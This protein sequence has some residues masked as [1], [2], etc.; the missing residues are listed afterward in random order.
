MSARRRHRGWAGF[1]LLEMLLAVVVLSMVGV[2]V[3]TML[4]QA[5]E[6]S[7]DNDRRDATLDVT[8]VVRLMNEQWDDRRSTIA[9]GA[10]GEAYSAEPGEISFVTARSILNQEWP[11]V[12][13]RY[14]VMLDPASVIEDER[15]Y[16]LIYEE[17]PL[18]RRDARLVA[19]A[20]ED[21]E[22]ARARMWEGASRH[23]LLKR[24]TNLRMERFR[25]LEQSAEERLAEEEGDRKG[26]GRT[27]TEEDASQDRLAELIEE[28]SSGWVAFDRGTAQVPG[29][30]R[31]LGEYE[32]EAF[33]CVFV[34]AALR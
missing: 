26:R 7:S 21:A 19:A 22:S 18:F 10:N 25:S 2:L 23:V 14:R 11:L 17:T 24:C 13:V 12:L 32:G 6:L 4:A 30:V 34:G 1:T 5:K 27:R 9:I 8:R 3:A 16:D 31:I 33:G 20:D 28:S 29:A 15:R